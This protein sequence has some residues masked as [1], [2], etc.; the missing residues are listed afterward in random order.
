MAV[1]DQKDSIKIKSIRRSF[2]GT[3]SRCRVRVYSD[4]H[5]LFDIK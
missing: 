1:G 4:A 3:T 2:L 5:P